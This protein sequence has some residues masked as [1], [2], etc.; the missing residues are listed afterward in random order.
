[1]NNKQASRELVKIANLLRGAVRFDLEDI[2][3]YAITFQRDAISPGKLNSIMSRAISSEKELS[4]RSRENIAR[5][6][7]G[8]SDIVVPKRGKFKGIPLLVTGFGSPD[9]KLDP[10]SGLPY[11]KVNKLICTPMYKDAVGTGVRV[12]IPVSEM[13]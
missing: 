9:L 6:S 1:M 2:G 8:V 13:R 5:T 12:Y 11:G 3:K 7:W 4:R 10:F